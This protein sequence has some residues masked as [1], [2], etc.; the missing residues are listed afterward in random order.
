MSIE[1]L[2]RRFTI[3]QYHQMAEAGIL[4][5]DDRVE[6]IRGEIVEMTPIGRRHAACVDRLNEMFILRLAQATIVRVQNPV[7]LDDNSEPQ[8]DLVLL[9]RRADF[10]EAGHPQAEDILLLV[11]VADTTVEADRDVK[12]LLYANSGIAEVWLV[13]I[14][15][16]CLEVYRQPSENGYQIIHKYYR[17]QTVTIQAFPE[18]SFTVD[19]V[20]G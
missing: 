17:G 10:Y 5:E 8:P 14:N 20:M 9:R 16:Q 12:I 2:R 1:L 7:E 11:E 15:A 18:V 19:E 13:D 4:T 6:L 3:K